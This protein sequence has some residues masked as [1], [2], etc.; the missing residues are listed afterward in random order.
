MA[1]VSPRVFWNLVKHYGG[2]VRAGLQQLLPHTDWAFLDERKRARSDKAEANSR[3]AAEG[4][5][6]RAAAAAARAPL[7][8][9][10]VKRLKMPELKERLKERGLD[11]TGKK[12]ELVAR[13]ESALVAEDAAAGAAGAAGAAEGGE[14]AEA[15]AAGAAAAAA[16]AA[17]E[18]E[19]EDDDGEGEAAEGPEAWEARGR[20]ATRRRELDYASECM[21][22]ALVTRQEALGCGEDDPRLAG[23]WYL[24]GF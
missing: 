22:S 24:H 21:Q 1:H 15:L 20:R 16:A 3:Q 10:G 14:A 11:T 18:E 13:L 8:L 12:D 7:L 5:H 9:A 17:A 2:D 19:D 23:A 6:G 4:A